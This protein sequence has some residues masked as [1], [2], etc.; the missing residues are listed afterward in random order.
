MF[1]YLAV[2]SLIFWSGYFKKNRS[3][4]IFSLTILCLMSAFRDWRLGGS[5][6]YIYHT[7]FLSATDVSVLF[8]GKYSIG[9]AALNFLIRAITKNYLLFQIAYT[10]LTT[11]LLHK[12]LSNLDLSWE[13][14]C[15]AIFGYFCLRFI[16]NDWIALRQNIAN[17]LF[18]YFSVSLYQTKYQQKKTKQLLFFCATIFIPY[19]FHSSAIINAILIWGVWLFSKLKFKLKA[20]IVVVG[21][22]VL[23]ALGGRVLSPLISIMTTLISDRYDMYAGTAEL[24]SNVIYFVLRLMFFIAFC[25][26]YNADR[27][28][29]RDAEFDILCVMMLISS[30]DL[31][32]VSRVFEYYAIGLY[33][34]IGTFS[35]TFSHRSRSAVALIFY[36]CMIAILARFLLT[37]NSPPFI[38]YR[39]WRT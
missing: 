14:K 36:F 15:T 3:A 18:W 33:S 38:P 9:Y 5:D 29:T 11:W 7:Y 26:R 10:I 1:V 32:I 16:Y 6:A 21:S 17:L 13:E 24:G 39:F 34:A 2:A 37:F 19:M 30:I 8:K 31:E 23:H 4:Y 28:K 35:R 12:V 20:G 22:V 27:S 25:Y